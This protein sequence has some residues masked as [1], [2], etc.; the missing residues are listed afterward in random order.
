MESNKKQFPSNS[1][2]NAE[3]KRKEVRQLVKG[4]ASFKKKS[5]GRKIT[6]NM[7]ASDGKSVGDYIFFDI[8]IPTIKEMICS[9]VESA[10]NIMMFGERRGS[11]RSSRDGG[12]SRVY[13]SY[14]RCYEDRDKRDSRKPEYGSYRNNIINEVIF[15]D[16]YDAQEVLR[17]MQ[18]LIDEF[19]VASVRDLCSMSRLP[20]DYTA[21]KY[22]WYEIGDEDAYIERVREGYL[23]HLPKPVILD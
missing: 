3:S 18:E 8:V 15:K 5:I 6:E 11:S 12:K 13:T 2:T 21:D 22:G 10:V 23:L 17:G 4:P 19:H 7:F 16:S 1:F 20:V 14:N 9:T